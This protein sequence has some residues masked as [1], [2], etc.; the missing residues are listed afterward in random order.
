MS[1]S[2]AVIG[3]AK[4]KC[5]SCGDEGGE[6]LPHERVKQGLKAGVYHNIDP[7]TGKRAKKKNGTN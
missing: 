6:V 2:D 7:N 5:P 4:R 1:K 3:T